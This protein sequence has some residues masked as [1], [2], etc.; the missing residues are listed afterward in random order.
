MMRI[1]TTAEFINEYDTNIN[2]TDWETL[3]S[4]SQIVRNVQKNGDDALRAYSK[5]FDSVEIDGLKISTDTLEEAYNNLDLELREA[6][7]V[8]SRNITAYE[9]TILH[10]QMSTNELYSKIHPLNRVGVYVPGGTAPLVSTVLMTATLAKVAGV[11]EIVAV[12][13]PQVGGVSQAILA[14]CFIAG[15]SEVYQVGGAQAIAALAYGTESIPRVD[16][17]AGPGNKYVAAAKKVVYGDVG[18]DS[19]AGPSEIV[20]VIDETADIEFIAFDIMAQAEHD[21]NARTFLV[22]TDEA[23]IAAVEAI[24]TELVENQSR[25]D[26]IK[27]SMA[28]NHFAIH[29]IS[30]DENVKVANLIAGEHVSIQTKDAKDYVDLIT[31]A[32]ALFIGH[33]VPEALGDYIAGP[34]HVLPTGGTARFSSGL[35]S[36]DFLRTNSILDVSKEKFIELA[37]YGMRLA[38]EEGLQAHYRSLA[39]RLA[40]KEED[41]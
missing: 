5:Q 35:T 1:Y 21:V 31:T 27:Q 4:V 41:E 15:V 8:A 24:V 34:S 29:T 28:K 17:I 37:P 9:E 26:I 7:E 40:D 3:D 18:I 11:K 14:A 16:K 23:Q 25:K 39:V 38:E 32:G 22:S 2:N 33:Y 36:N 30:R 10:R 20:L 12:T 13:P 6:L 19:I